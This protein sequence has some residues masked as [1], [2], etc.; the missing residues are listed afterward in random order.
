MKRLVKITCATDPNIRKQIRD[1]ANQ[2]T[3]V[4]D[5][6][7]ISNELWDY[8]QYNTLPVGKITIYIRGDWKHDHLRANYLLKENFDLMPRIDENVTEDTGEDWYPA[9]HT[10]Y[11]LLPR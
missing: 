7:G 5:A 2:M 6:D 10:Y 3:D 9:T 1:I 11:V 4:L 8:E